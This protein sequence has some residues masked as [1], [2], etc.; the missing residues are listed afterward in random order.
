MTSGGAGQFYGAHLVFGDSGYGVQLERA[1][2]LVR[3]PGDLFFDAE[4][5]EGLRT[6]VRGHLA[7]HETLDTPTYKELIGTSR[8][9][10]VPLMELLDGEKLTVRRG[11]VRVRK[12]GG[13]R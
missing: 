7:D 1:G 12:S 2:E 10:A 13:T 6:R 5:V 4:A 11:D 3:A 9:H 8:K